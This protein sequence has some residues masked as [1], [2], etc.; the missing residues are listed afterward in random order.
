MGY[1]ADRLNTPDRA[2]DYN[3][4]QNQRKP[5]FFQVDM[6]AYDWFTRLCILILAPI[7]CAG[8]GDKL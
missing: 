2:I 6:Q 1:P 3:S 5:A 7:P 8:I 4:E